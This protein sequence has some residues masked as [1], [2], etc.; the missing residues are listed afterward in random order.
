MKLIFLLDAIIQAKT[1]LVVKV[2]FTFSSHWM[3]SLSLLRHT[4]KKNLLLL[5]HV[6]VCILN[7]WGAAEMILKMILREIRC[8]HSRWRDSQWRKVIIGFLW[9][10]L[11]N[12]VWLTEFLE[13]ISNDFGRHPA[14]LHSFSTY[15]PVSCVVLQKSYHFFAGEVWNTSMM[16]R[17]LQHLHQ[18]WGPPNHAIPVLHLK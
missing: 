13:V 6:S 10:F 9:Y 5:S 17:L 14:E 2:P 4:Q 15:D 12:V 16:E 18:A 8:Q 11:K 3:A 7:Q 1:Y